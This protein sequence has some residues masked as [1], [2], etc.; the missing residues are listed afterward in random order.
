[1][2]LSRS[3]GFR[4]GA[5]VAA[6]LL[7]A[8]ASV[9]TG[10][11]QRTLHRLLFPPQDLGL[12]EGPDRDAW[13]KPD[14]IMDALGIAD[15]STV[16]DLGAGGGWFTI[17]LARRVGPNGLVYAEDIQTQM[18]EATSR[19]VAREGLQ[20]VRAVLG[21]PSDPRLPDGKLDAVLIVDAYHEMED[22]VSLLRNVRRTLKPTGR[23]G[24][25]D[26]K[27]DGGGPGPPLEDRVDPEVILR[28]A[29]AAGLQ[30][31]RREMFLPYQFLLILGG[32]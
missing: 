25:V 10:A 27:K 32:R 6:A 1:M 26:Y 2:P 8:A 7:L 21:T 19:R 15:G 31:I 20:N 14:R 12:L 28:D 30:L 4:A 22:P 23:I 29:T 18:L 9:R 17:R 24:V 13:Q 16:A 5:C 3:S 11:Q